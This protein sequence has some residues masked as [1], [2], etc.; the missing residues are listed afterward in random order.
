MFRRR[1]LLGA[2]GA[3]AALSPAAG[4]A[5]QPPL[6]PDVGRKFHPDGRVGPFGGNTVICHLPQQGAGSEPFNA[7]LDIYRAAPAHAFMRKVT[8]L[9][10]SSYHMTIFGG[11]NDSE[12]V[13]G[14]WPADLP[15]DL[16]MADCDRVLGERLKTF[17]LDCALPLRLRVDLA[18]PADTERPLTLR[19]LPFD[20]AENRKLRRLRDRLSERL[21]IR[22]P[23]H[24]TYRFHVTLGYLIRWLTPAEAAE[25]HVALRTWRETVARRCPVI[26]LGAPEYCTLNDMFAFHRQ[27]YLD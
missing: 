20:E 17:L 7:L 10:P 23:S 9:P 22:A 24:D 3:A 21:A 12:R 2:A 6:P 4:L 5:A 27:F 26:E 11:A 25:F 1:D 13:A 18:E 8:L 16:P 19:L 15:R 14:L